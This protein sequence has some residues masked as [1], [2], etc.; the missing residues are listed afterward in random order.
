MQAAVARIVISKRRI[1][2]IS[3]KGRIRSSVPLSDDSIQNR[4]R[5]SDRT[6]CGRGDSTD[7]PG[8]AHNRSEYSSQINDFDA[9]F[10]LSLKSPQRDAEGIRYNDFNRGMGYEPIFS[11]KRSP[12]VVTIG[13]R[14]R[15]S[16]DRQ[17][18]RSADAQC[19]RRAAQR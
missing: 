2:S 6:P 19:R 11:P 14:A 10:S 13:C 17:R 9:E 15:T 8:R 5:L 12:C 18:R 4:Y 7:S 3:G 1:P 16:L